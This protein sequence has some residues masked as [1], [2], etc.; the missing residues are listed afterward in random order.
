MASMHG[1]WRQVEETARALGLIGEHLAGL[2]AAAC[3]W[4]MDSPVSNS[5]RLKA[6]IQEIAAGR[7][8]NWQ[9][10]LVLNPDA[11]LARSD[12]I[13]A[14]ADSVILDRCR[15]WYNLAREVVVAA[16]PQAHVVLRD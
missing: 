11:V 4:Y 5:G 9:V 1:T 15:R 8:W 16:V 12:E 13:V 3:M 7:G 14:T 2:P 6:G 10:E